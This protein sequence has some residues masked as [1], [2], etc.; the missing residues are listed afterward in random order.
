MGLGVLIPRNP[1][2]CHSSSPSLH[3]PHYTCGQFASN[4][5]LDSEVIAQA[6]RTNASK[7]TTQ[8]SRIFPMTDDSQPSYSPSDPVSSSLNSQPAKR[9]QFVSL[10]VVRESP[11]ILYARRQIHC[12]QDAVDLVQPFLVDADREKFLVVVLDTKHNPSHI[13]VVSIGSLDASIVHP[14]EIFKIAIVANGSA[15]ICVHNHPSGDP[16]PSVGDVAV[17]KRLKDAGSLLGIKLLDHL[18]VGSDGRFT[19]FKGEGLI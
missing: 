7:S 9:V 6:V 5:L 15:I 14:R 13:Q 16:T 17:T 1:V 10:K 19:S 18:V 12:A 3:N 11:S 8:R 2:R 4:V